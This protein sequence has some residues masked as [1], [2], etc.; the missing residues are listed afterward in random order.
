M[1][2]LLASLLVMSMILVGCSGGN[3]GSK[4]AEI[5]IELLMLEILMINHSTKV[6]MKRLNNLS[7]IMKI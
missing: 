6:L 1:K 2:K 7:K 5:R 3:S 4:G